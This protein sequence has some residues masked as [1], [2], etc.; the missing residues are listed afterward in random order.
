MGHEVQQ[1][2]P[3]DDGP[4]LV[5][6]AAL[7]P[8]RAADGGGG[9]AVVEPVV[10]PGMSQ[11]VQ[12]RAGLGR[13]QDDV[14]GELEAARAPGAEGVVPAVALHQ[15]ERLAAMGRA[16]AAAGI[17]RQ[18]E[19][20]HPARSHEAQGLLHHGAVDQ[21]DRAALVVVSPAAPGVARCVHPSVILRRL[22]AFNP[23]DSAVRDGG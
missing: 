15:M 16:P 14:V 11:R 10:A 8:H 18:R 19:I 20:E 9:V 12:V 5:D 6:P 4:D 1:D 13:H 21:V 22:R 2:A 23:Q 3:G 17:E 7:R